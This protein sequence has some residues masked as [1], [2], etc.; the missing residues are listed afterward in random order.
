MMCFLEEG[1]QSTLVN[2]NNNLQ[3]GDSAVGDGGRRGRLVAKL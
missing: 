1:V 2:K 3:F